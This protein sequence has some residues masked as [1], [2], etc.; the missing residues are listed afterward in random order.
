MMGPRSFLPAL[1]TIASLSPG[2]AFAAEAWKPTGP[3]MFIVPN[4]PAGPSD[5]TA[6]E[7]ER[8]MRTHRIVEQ[9][10]VIVNRAGG[11]GTVAL[12]QL[13]ASPGDGHTLLIMNGATVS[14]QIMGLSP[15]GHADFTPL[16]V[17][18]DEYFGV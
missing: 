4:A 5:R 7:M 18:V 15:Y 11:G 14:A 16:S 1:C 8:I 12:N 2:P 9:P 10:I 6:R 13:R 3:I 17:M